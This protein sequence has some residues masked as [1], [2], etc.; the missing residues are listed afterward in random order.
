MDHSDAGDMSPVL[1]RIVNFTEQIITRIVDWSAS[2][3]LNLHFFKK[4]DHVSLVMLDF[5]SI[6]QILA[7]TGKQDSLRQLQNITELANDQLGSILSWRTTTIFKVSLFPKWKRGILFILDKGV[8]LLTTY[9]KIDWD[10][11]KHENPSSNQPMLHQCLTRILELERHVLDTR[12]EDDLNEISIKQRDV[13]FYQRIYSIDQNSRSSYEIERAEVPS[14][15]KSKDDES[16]I[17][18]T[19]LELLDDLDD[20]FS[21]LPANPYVPSLKRKR[22]FA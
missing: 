3:N 12:A 17:A 8:V 10:N 18:N 19:S 21:A 13:S 2:E 22:K 16:V 1:K 15:F 20:A 11:L 7:Q 4:E 9:N 5:G 14:L 6:G